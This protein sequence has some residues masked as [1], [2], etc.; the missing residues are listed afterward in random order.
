VFIRQL[1]DGPR[2]QYKTTSMKY[3]SVKCRNRQSVRNARKKHAQAQR[4]SANEEA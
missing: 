1:S 2:H 4:A 3:C